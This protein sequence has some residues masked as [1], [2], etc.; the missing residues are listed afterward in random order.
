M[1][2]GSR[3][4]GFSLFEMLLV[5]SLVTLISLI[6]VPSLQT[7]L[8]KHRADSTIS[9]LQSLFRFAETQSLKRGVKISLCPSFDGKSCGGDWAAGQMVFIDSDNTHQPNNQAAI[10]RVAPKLSHGRLWLRAFPQQ[11]FLQWSPTRPLAGQNGTFLY[12]PSQ[13]D[14]HLRRALVFNQ[15]GRLRVVS[16]ETVSLDCV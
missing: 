3:C 7:Q 11:G 14:S 5:V 16:G 1:L 13:P 9:R 10:L 12:C 8:A 15:T 6:G 2:S 4:T